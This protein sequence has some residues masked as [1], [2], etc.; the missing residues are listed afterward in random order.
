[1]SQSAASSN[2]GELLAFIAYALCYP[3]G[4]LALL[5]TYD[6]LASGLPN[7]LSVA[8]ALHQIGYRALGVRLDSGDLAYISRVTRSLFIEVGLRYNIDYFKDLTIVASNDLSEST[9]LSLNAQGHQINCFGVGTN[10]VTCSAQPALGCVFK[11]VSL[12][13]EPRIKLSE[14]VI[15]V[16]IPG[17]KEVYRLIDKNGEP[18]FDVMC[19]VSGEKPEA[20]KRFLCRHPTEETKRAYVTPSRVICLHHCFW[21]CQGSNINQV[22]LKPL[23]PSMEEIRQFTIQQIDSMRPDYLRPLNPTPYKLALTSELYDFFHDLW[24]REAPIREFS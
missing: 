20:G 15:K 12:Q 6:T 18:I 23:L 16:P 19:L 17:R 5:D 9:I 4:F 21:D 3:D 7:F 8:L 14:D 13:G 1:M 22:D 2:G 10:L 11:L 24:L